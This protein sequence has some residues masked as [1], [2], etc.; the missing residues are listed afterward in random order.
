MRATI[1][2]LVLIIS[3]IGCTEVVVPTAPSTNLPPSVDAKRNTIEFRVT[4]NASGVRVRYSNGLDGTVQLNTTL[5]FTATFQSNLDSAF[6]FL[7]ATPTGFF[8]GTFNPFLSAQIYINSILFREASSS[9]FLM[10]TLS[11]SGNYRR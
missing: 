10:N 6:L 9:D 1:I 3:T 2:A 8:Q 5:P 4:G 7:E 11:V